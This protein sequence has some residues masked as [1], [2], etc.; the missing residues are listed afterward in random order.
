[1][2]GLAGKA[3]Q[4]QLYNFYSEDEVWADTC[5]YRPAYLMIK[6]MNNF[7][8]FKYKVDLF[9]TPLKRATHILKEAFFNELN[10]QWN[11]YN[12][13]SIGHEIHPVWKHRRWKNSMLSKVTNVQ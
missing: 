4:D 8:K 5:F 9:L 2:H 12:G 7:S 10:E 3:A 13:C 11:N 6:R 1:M